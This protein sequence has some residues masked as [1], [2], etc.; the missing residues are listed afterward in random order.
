MVSGP[1]ILNTPS[2]WC[3]VNNSP[4]TLNKTQSGEDDEKEDT[5]GNGRAVIGF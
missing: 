5:G 1:R 3:D 2:I 4:A